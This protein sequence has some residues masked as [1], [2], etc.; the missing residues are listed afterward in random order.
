MDSFA[1]SG[2]TS[3]LPHR[4]PKVPKPLLFNGPGNL[5]NLSSLSLRNLR[6]VQYARPVLV[7]R[8]G[9]RSS[10]RSRTDSESDYDDQ[11]RTRETVKCK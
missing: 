1:N 11:D 2:C 3:L 6:E 9:E 4:L 10:Q 5:G 8:S 7:Y